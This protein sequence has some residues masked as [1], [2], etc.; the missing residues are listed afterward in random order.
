MTAYEDKNM[1]LTTAGAR[2]LIVALFAGKGY[3][4]RTEIIETLTRYHNENGG[5]VTPEEKRVSAVK[6]ALR[7]LEEQGLA[8]RRPRRPGFWRIHTEFM[9]KYPSPAREIRKNVG[10][11]RTSK[12][13]RVFVSYY[14]AEDQDYRERFEDLFSDIYDIYVSESVEM[15]DLDPDLKTETIRQKIRD[16][17]LRDST[18]TVV[19]VGARTWQRK[20]VD[21][22]IGSSLRNTQKNRRSGLL[23]ILL[24]TYPG[25][26]NNTY[27]PHT[28]PPRLYDNIKSGYATIYCWS[29]DPDTLQSWIHEAFKRRHE[30]TPPDNARASFKNNRSGDR[31]SD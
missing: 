22:E 23:G 11:H 16:D 26:V 8:E 5:R 3:I 24:P 27:H 30:K 14:H 31:W 18:V 6:L 28:I 4:K 20:F 10:N 17:Y 7:D 29:E 1:P 15:G 25:Y 19:L 13:H 12:R 2:D 9:R 21:W